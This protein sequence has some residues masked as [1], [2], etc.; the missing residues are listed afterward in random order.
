M[1]LWLVSPAYQRFALSDICFAQR[2]D[3]LDSLRAAG[4][5]CEQVVVADDDNLD[6]AREHGFHTVECP[7]TPLGAKF[8]AGWEYAY[9]QGA[10]WVSHIGSDGWIL[11]DYY[12]HDFESHLLYT[13]PRYAVVDQDG[14]RLF[15]MDIGGD[16]GT[17]PFVVHRSRLDRYKGRPIDDGLPKGI[18]TSLF[19]NLA[20]GGSAWEWMEPDPL[21]LVGFKSRPQIVSYDELLRAWPGEEYCDPFDTLRTRYRARH[22]DAVEALY[23]ERP[24]L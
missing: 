19:R 17:G 14:A 5:E 16:Y 24:W 6:I 11:A 9:R 13:S 3:V 18:D 1:T 22:V 21:A 2:A 23:E 20:R 10:E 15:A 8:N 12:R 7:N 4:V